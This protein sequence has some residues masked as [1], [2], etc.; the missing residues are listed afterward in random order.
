M[1]AVASLPNW[2]FGDLQPRSYRTVLADPPWYFKN[3]SKKGEAKNPVAH[4]ACMEMADIKALPV[5]ALAHPDGCW[6]VMWATFPMLPHALATM[7]AWGFTFKSGGAWAKQ[8]KSGNALSFGPGYTFRAAAEL[9]L[10]GSIGNP[11][12]L[13]H[14]QRNLILDSDAGPAIV[15][16][17]REHSRKP[18]EMIAICEAMFSGPRVELFCRE[19]RPGWDAWGNQLGKFEAAP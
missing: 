4:Y 17:V 12:V 7:D 2:P 16:P 3:F 11:K 14:S 6:L 15:A 1:S 10:L 19:R 13:S 5:S 18:D 8:S 9:F